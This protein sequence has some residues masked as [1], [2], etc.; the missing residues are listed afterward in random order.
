ML[1]YNYNQGLNDFDC[2]FLKS[3]SSSL[4]SLLYSASFRINFF[5]LLYPF[6]NSSTQPSPLWKL[7]VTASI[8]SSSW[9]RATGHVLSALFNRHVS[10]DVTLHRS[11]S[12]ARVG[13]DPD[14][15]QTNYFWRTVT[16]SFTVD[17]SV[18]VFLCMWANVCCFRGRVDRTQRTHPVCG[19]FPAFIFTSP[20]SLFCISFLP[21][22]LIKTSSNL[23][24]V[25]VLVVSH[26]GC[27]TRWQS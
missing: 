26:R 6:L 18:D 19:V 10:F 11:R 25:V 17:S 8:L 2:G 4:V 15:D 16:F 21:A 3:S 23:T 9:N 14:S 12:A 5:P 1:Y 13:G 7:S 22:L 24:S 20:P 27:E